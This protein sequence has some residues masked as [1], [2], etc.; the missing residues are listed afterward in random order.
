MG[1]VITQFGLGQEAAAAATSGD[2]K[3]FLKAVEDGASAPGPQQP[4][5]DDEKKQSKEKKDD[6]KDDDS[7]MSVD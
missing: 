1:P 2:V 4:K 7:G 5:T 6:K 3:G